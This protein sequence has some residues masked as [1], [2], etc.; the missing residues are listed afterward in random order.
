MATDLQAMKEQRPALPKN[1]PF[2]KLLQHSAEEIKRALPAHLKPERMVRIALTA[3]RRTPKLAQCEP[4]SVLAAVIQAAQ[5]GLEPDT[6]G[7]SYLVPYGKECQFIPGWKG[8][9]EMLHRSGQGHVHTGVIYR[10]QK[11]R[12]TDGSTRDL[13]ILNETALWEPE[14]ITHAFAVGKIKGSGDAIIE[15]WPVERL[16]KHRD[17]YNKVGKR[18]YSFDNWEMYI[19]KVVLLQVLKY[20]PLSADLVR[21]VELDHAAATGS[22]G[23]T[24]DGAIDGEWEPVQETE[25]DN[26]GPSS[27]SSVK[28]TSDAGAAQEENADAGGNDDQGESKSGQT[29][30]NAPPFGSDWTVDDFVSRI[31]E[32]ETTVRIEE[33][34]DLARSRKDLSRDDKMKIRDAAM[35]RMSD[36]DGDLE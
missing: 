33:Y 23:L 9:V 32:A 10:D 26:T 12:F 29:A 2:P 20:M 8:L 11:Y 18:H 30:D 28:T 21:S 15:L 35:A 24:I 5:L 6:L 4:K 1:A 34:V 25:D 22:Q 7:R 16:K 36:G 31:A 27:L 14:A 3:F 19:R 17:K 13:V